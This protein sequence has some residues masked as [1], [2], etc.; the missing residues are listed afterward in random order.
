LPGNISAEDITVA[1]Q[2]MDYDVIN[3]KEKTAKRPTPEGQV[4][5]TSL[6]LSLVVIA[7]NQKAPE[8]LK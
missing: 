6:H 1:L 3:V 8:F 5:Y 7:R 2:K 4:T